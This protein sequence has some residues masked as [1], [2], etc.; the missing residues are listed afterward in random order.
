M[1]C[2]VEPAPSQASLSPH[3]VPPHAISSPP[4]Q[5][6]S[7]PHPLPPHTIKPAPSQA[8]HL[9]LALAHNLSCAIKPA[10]S[11]T[12][13]GPHHLACTPLLCPSPSHHQACTILPLTLAP[14]LPPCTIELMLSCTYPSA[15]PLTLA[16]MPHVCTLT[17]ALPLAH[18][19]LPPC[20]H[21]HAT[22]CVQGAIKLIILHS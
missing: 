21:P 3:P 22:S 9:E 16:C 1:P 5:A 14:S 10:L 20:H 4:S 2:T 18:M 19:P 13:P 6:A 17:I 8:H 15:I 11:C 12:Y 7:R